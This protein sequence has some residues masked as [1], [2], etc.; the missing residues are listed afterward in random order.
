MKLL[1]ENSVVSTL[2]SSPSGDN[3]KFLSNSHSLWKRFENYKKNPPLGLEVD[4]KIVSVIFCT[5]NRDEYV[6]LY[7]IVT[8][9]GN[10]GKGYASWLWREFIKYSCLEKKC[11]RLKLSCTP[12]SLTWHIRNGLVFWGVDPTGSLRSDQ[13]IF[14]TVQEQKDYRDACVKHPIIGIPCPKVCKKLALETIEGHKFSQKK[15]EEVN[16]AIATA[17]KFWLRNAL[18]QK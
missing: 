14:Q 11:K 9:Q 1:S 17:G 6:N 8:T 2:N 13:R 3:T 7:E 16:T 4:G 15:L 12:S 18:F 5:Y 10:E